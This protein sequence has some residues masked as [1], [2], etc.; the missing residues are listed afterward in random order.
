MWYVNIDIITVNLPGDVRMT[1]WQVNKC[2]TIET[3][4]LKI[5]IYLLCNYVD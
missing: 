5:F 3:G 1:L 2:Q 4:Y